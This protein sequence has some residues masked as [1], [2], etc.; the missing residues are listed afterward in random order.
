[1]KDVYILSNDFESGVLHHLDRAGNTEVVPTIGINV[2][3]L[4]FPADEERSKMCIRT[5]L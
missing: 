2:V 1:M 3:I 4:I 5:Y